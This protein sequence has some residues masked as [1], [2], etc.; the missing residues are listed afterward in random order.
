[1]ANQALEALRQQLNGKVPAGLRE[2]ENE[3]LEHLA[4]AVHEAH[5]R[6]GQALA[7]AGERAL[8]HIPRLLRGPVRRV[9][10]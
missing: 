1:V 3:H 6:Q 5:R 4:S 9:M 8:G 7:E 10:R 2:L